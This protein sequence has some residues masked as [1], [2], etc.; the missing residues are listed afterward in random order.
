MIKLAC[1][2]N[3]FLSRNMLNHLRVTV[4]FMHE[5]TNSGY[6][7]ELFHVKNNPK[8]MNYSTLDTRMWK[9][10][11]VFD[12]AYFQSKMRQIITQRKRLAYTFNKAICCLWVMA[13]RAHHA[14]TSHGY[15]GCEHWTRH[16]MFFYVMIESCSYK[17]IKAVTYRIG[18]YLT[19]FQTS[20]TVFNLRTYRLIRTDTVWY[21]TVLSIP[22]H[23]SIP[24]FKTW[25]YNFSFT[26]EWV[27][28]RVFWD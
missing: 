9:N 17:Q 15:E 6:I 24:W 11:E 13:M 28:L 4:E 26:I 27:V 22:F 7:R 10:C 3:N 18:R 19:G 23:F 16:L 5:G 25:V 14:K 20:D 8:S 1:A 12:H 21:M 2:C